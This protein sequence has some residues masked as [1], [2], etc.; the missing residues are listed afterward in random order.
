[1]IT[2]SAPDGIPEIAAGADLAALVVQACAADPLRDGDIVVVTSKIV[3]KAED[4]FVPAGQRDALVLTEARRTVAV[5]GRT[6][7]VGTEH[8]LVLAGAGIDN[9]NVDPAWVLLLPADPDASAAR[10]RDAFAERFGV[11][12]GVV[13]SDTAGRPWREGQV[14]QAIGA[15]GVRVADDFAGRTDDYGNDLM[16]TK[17]AYADEI[18][19]AAELVKTKLGGR[20]VAVVRG[21]GHLVGDGP[22]RARDLVRPPELDLFAYGSREAVLAAVLVAMGAA[23]RYEELVGLPPSACAARV[24]ADRGLGDEAAAL[25]ERI[26]SADLT[27]P[28]ADRKPL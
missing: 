27:M 28:G 20:P 19:A 21:L 7:I 18:A 12:V 17:M 9:S 24:L 14:D 3:S 5:R 11:R 8:G 4:R 13:V 2:V 26:L 16:V 15:A 1:M 10:L 25:V 23:D 22:D 6:R